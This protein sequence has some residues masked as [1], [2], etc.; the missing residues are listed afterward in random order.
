MTI[1][2]DGVKRSRALAE[3][4]E[5]EQSIPD[6]LVTIERHQN[7]LQPVTI[8]RRGV[9]RLAARGF[10]AKDISVLLDLN[11]NTFFKYFKREVELGRAQVKTSLKAH[12]IN[13]AMRE[14]PQPAI[15]IFAAKSFAG[16]SE[17]GQDE[18]GEPITS[19]VNV[20]INVLQ[21]KND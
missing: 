15:L 2:S 7:R 1:T 17:L 12:V 13:E 20:S 10:S 14:K 5:L 11:Y 19:D 16:L 21:K 3:L 9:F 18:D 4:E 6:E 8:T